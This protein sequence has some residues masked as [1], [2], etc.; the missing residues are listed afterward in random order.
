MRKMYVGLILAVLTCSAMVEA[1]ESE[2]VTT[3]LEEVDAWVTTDTARILAF[4]DSNNAVTTETI[5]NSKYWDEV[6]DDLTALLGIDYTGNPQ[7]DNTG[8]I[9]FEMRITGES[10]HLFYMDG[11]MG[12]PH[13][14]TP[15]HWAEEGYTI[16][17]YNVHPSGNFLLV[18]MNKHGDEMHDIWLFSRDGTFRPL[19]VDRQVRYGNPIFDPDNAHQFYLYKNPKGGAITLARYDMMTDELDSIYTEPGWNIPVDY[20]QGKIL[21]V[22]WFSF[23]ASQLAMY[24]VTTG[25]VTDL[26]DTAL[27]WG[28]AFTPDGRVATLTSARS[29][30]D[31]FMKMCLLDPASPK[32]FTVLYDPR[33]YE[34]DNY[35]MSEEAGI[36]YVL[37]NREGYSEIVGIDL[38]GRMVPAP[39]L[40][41]GVI[42]EL[43]VDDSGKLAFSFSSPKMPPTIYHF[44]PADRP[45]TTATDI[46]TFGFDFSTVSVDVIEYPSEDGTMI[47]ALLYT[48]RDAQKNGSNPAIINYHGGPPSQ[49][50]PMFQRNIAFALSRGF[51]LMFPNVRGSSGYGPEWEK[52]D[53]LEDAN[54]ATPRSNP[55]LTNFTMVGSDSSSKGCTFRRG[56]SVTLKNSIITNAGAGEGIAHDTVETVEYKGIVLDNTAASTVMTPDGTADNTGFKGVY[57]DSAG[58]DWND[59]PDDGDYPVDYVPLDIINPSLGGATP[60]TATSDYIGAV[61]YTTVTDNDNAWYSGWIQQDIN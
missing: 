24:D 8:R 14:L 40:E 34:I 42:N 9:Y 26:S 47:P 12:W 58:D 49:S 60:D 19:L 43:A 29:S 52:A 50:R 22:R 10:P 21:F 53:N 48:P 33:K 31:E 2:A 45:V 41:I 30:E 46:A 23:S 32:E 61:D 25:A 3:Y 51:V 20:R 57:T 37:L 54:D 13:Q 36:I 15:N 16:S 1:Q 56:T 55:T 18:S 7:L 39:E 6:K 38:S 11:P 35:A 44:D 17:G 4:I 28:A 5:K 59:D 27:F